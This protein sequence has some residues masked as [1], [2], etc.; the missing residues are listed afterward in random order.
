[1][2][3]KSNELTLG[4]RRLAWLIL[5]IASSGA[6][7]FAFACA[8]PIAAFAAIGTC[9]LPRRDALSLSVGVW[10]ANQAIGFAF[11]N[12]PW[13]WNCLAWGA[14]LGLSAVTATLAARGAIG[15]I[16][17]PHVIATLAG[18]LVAAF[19][20]Y[21][22]VIVLSSILLGGLANFSPAIQGRIFVV[23]AA[24]LVGL[25]ALHWAGVAVGIAS[26]SRFPFPVADRAA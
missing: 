5:L 12:Y 15:R 23:N 25:V 22:A 21:E 24:A 16:G 7:T 18:A 2:T 13:T 14:A 26:R 20:T 6:F 11:L 4:W 8:V 19:V 9:T 17:A 3:Y 10:L 1:M